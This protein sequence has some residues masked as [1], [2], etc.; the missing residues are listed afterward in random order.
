M[1]VL[2]K[3]WVLILLVLFVLAGA[4]SPLVVTSYH[5]SVVQ[6]NQN[7]AIDALAEFARQQNELFKKEGHYATSFQELGGE[8]SKVQDFVSRNPSDFHGYR[9][10]M[11]TSQSA[12]SKS[13]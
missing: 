12:D 7:A 8:W 9:F 10:R 3:R 5:N 4:L 1:A 2:S 13:T 11:F 6:N